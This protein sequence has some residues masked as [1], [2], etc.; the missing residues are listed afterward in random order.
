MIDTPTEMTAVFQ[1]LRQANIILSNGKLNPQA[2]QMLEKEPELVP[3]V[4]DA[5]SFIR[6]PCTTKVRLQCIAGN[7][8]E[9]GTCLNCGK[10]LTFNNLYRSFNSVCVNTKGSSCGM[11]SGFSL[12]KM[13]K[14]N[15]LRY[16]T[17]NAMQNTTIKAKIK[18]TMLERFGGPAPMCSAQ[19]KAKAAKTN[20]ERTFEQRQ[21]Q[22]ESRKNTMLQ[23]YGAP[24]YAQSLLELPSLEKLNDASW[25]TDQLYRQGKTK[26]LIGIELNVSPGTILAAMKRHKIQQPTF[27]EGDREN[28]TALLKNKDWLIDQYIAKNVPKT[29]IAKQL[30]VHS[31]YVHAWCIKHNIPKNKYV[32]DRGI[33]ADQREIYAMIKSATNSPIIINQRSIIPPQELD[34]WLPHLKVAFEFNGTLWHSE[35]KGKKSKYHLRKTIATEQIGGQLFHI[36]APYWSH[37]QK[38]ISSQIRHILHCSTRIYARHC[39]IKQM[40]ALE[41][42]A[43][44]T[45]TN[46]YGYVASKVVYG[47]YIQKQCVA[48]MSFSKKQKQWSI[49]RYSC[50]LDTTV[51]GGLSKLFTHFVR[52]NSPAT[53]T[54]H[55]DRSWGATKSLSKIGFVHIDNTLPSYEYFHK[56]NTDVLLPRQHFQKHK[57]PKLLE[58]FDPNL[59]EWENMQVNGYNRIW[60]CGQ[61]VWRWNAPVSN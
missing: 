51:I 50:A 47:L 20:Q 14:T 4:L 15:M 26:K 18:K 2:I 23:K 36:W 53:V 13:Q 60:D 61:S 46:L 25:L 6:V 11:A 43:F 21:K 9:Q 49:V 5:T 33:S 3:L 55:I 40:T 38:I 45:E 28:A 44:F 27:I 42:Q 57:L 35:L 17:A 24:T 10:D 54:A 30:G 39:T 29:I 48:A 19:V 52:T 56:N 34:F 58:K 16:G 12:K 41:Q 7:I 59:T 22:T 1:L 32:N 8:T 31:T 37:K